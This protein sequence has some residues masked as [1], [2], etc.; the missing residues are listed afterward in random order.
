MMNGIRRIYTLSQVR[1]LEGEREFTADKWRLTS[2][3]LLEA[4]HW[5]NFRLISG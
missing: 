1:Q 5:A 3:F 4:V 2:I